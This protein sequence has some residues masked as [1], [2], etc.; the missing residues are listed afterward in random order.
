VPDANEEDGELSGDGMLGDMGVVVKYMVV[1]D[2]FHQAVEDEGR[3]TKSLS[4]AI[5]MIAS[6][7]RQKKVQLTQF[8]HRGS[9]FQDP[10][11]KQEVRQGQDSGIAP[12]Q[13]CLFKG[14]KVTRAA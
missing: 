6:K 4:K 13:K 12:L 5:W 10:C 2:E 8:L 7:V 9:C 11:C 3:D 14:I 1:L